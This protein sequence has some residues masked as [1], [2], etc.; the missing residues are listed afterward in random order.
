L[1]GQYDERTAGET[2]ATKLLDQTYELLA[3]EIMRLKIFMK[4]E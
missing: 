1:T 2:Y 3:E 4:E